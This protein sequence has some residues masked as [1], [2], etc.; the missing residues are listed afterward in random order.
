[1]AVMTQP[2]ALRTLESRIQ[3][4]LMRQLM[5]GLPMANARLGDVE[6]FLTREGGRFTWVV[7][8]DGDPPT[9]AGSDSNLHLAVTDA[10][11]AAALVASRTPPSS[12]AA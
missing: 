7:M 4:M 9:H 8:V 2:A 3:R 1:M 11:C 10:A 5:N 6:V 12:R